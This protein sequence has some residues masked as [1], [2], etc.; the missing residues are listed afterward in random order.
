MVKVFLM[1][2]IDA[3]PR[4][5]IESSLGIGNVSFTS[6]ELHNKTI[7]DT[8]WECPY[9]LCPTY[10]ESANVV[11]F[12]RELLRTTLSNHSYFDSE[13]VDRCSDKIVSLL[14]EAGEKSLT[15]KELGQELFIE[16]LRILRDLVLTGDSYVLHSKETERDMEILIELSNTA[17]IDKLLKE[18]IEERERIRN[19]Y[20]KELGEHISNFEEYEKYKKSDIDIEEII[21]HNKESLIAGLNINKEQHRVYEIKA[22]IGILSKLTVNFSDNIFEL[23]KSCLP[24]IQ[25]IL[26]SK[27]NT[28]IITCLLN[29]IKTALEESKEFSEWTKYSLRK[30]LPTIEDDTL[31]DIIEPI[32]H[33]F[34]EEIKLTRIKK[35][36]YEHDM[37]SL[38]DYLE[39]YKRLISKDECI[40]LAKVI[41]DY[42]RDENIILCFKHLF[43]IVLDEVIEILF[44]SEAKD[45]ATRAFN[46]A[47]CDISITLYP[48]ILLKLI[49][50]HKALMVISNLVWR[51]I[52]LSK[53]MLELILNALL[54]HLDNLK[55]NLGKVLSLKIILHLLE[56][57][58]LIKTESLLEKIKVNKSNEAIEYYYD[59]IK[60][61]L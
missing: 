12:R 20:A 14:F 51:D 59:R 31:I 19:K 11:S 10:S 26:E 4:S 23:Q 56:T 47:A 2:C 37:K 52:E 6:T 53:D 38:N 60:A 45:I 43:E 32:I 24:L 44:N 34:N 61:L 7:P 29:F 49:D 28:E 33:D 35:E 18:E 58:K 25:D 22:I 16:F 42:K 55:D 17:L 41:S 21:K 40:E 15:T 46:Y 54:S 39:T 3:I 5:D 27:P 30:L 36:E 13:E 1:K 48:K 57:H 9:S 8:E 50:Y